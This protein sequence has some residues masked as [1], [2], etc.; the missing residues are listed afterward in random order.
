M[1]GSA[2]LCSGFASRV[3]YLP[4]ASPY[5]LYKL[6]SQLASPLPVADLPHHGIHGRRAASPPPLPPCNARL[7]RSLCY[8]LAWAEHP[9]SVLSVLS[10]LSM[11]ECATPE[12]LLT[13]VVIV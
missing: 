8:K 1:M 7:Q 11:E 5:C 13:M 3:T 12:A 2:L 9:L 6:V 10:V 4:G